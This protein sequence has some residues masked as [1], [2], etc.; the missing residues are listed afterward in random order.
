LLIK[1][2]KDHLTMK[3]KKNIKIIIVAL[4]IVSFLVTITSCVVANSKVGETDND[5]TEAVVNNDTESLTDEI[6]ESDTEDYSLYWPDGGKLNRKLY[7]ALSEMSDDE[8]IRVQITF[9]YDEPDKEYFIELAAKKLGLKYDKEE[10]DIVYGSNPK[11]ELIQEYREVKR[12]IQEEYEFERQ[13]EFAEKYLKSWEIGQD[14]ALR[15]PKKVIFAELSKK[16]IND[17]AMIE[18]VGCIRT[19]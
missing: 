1:I 10:G 5:E 18:D 8:T 19:D 2:R 17:L 6:T 7:L 16:E 13:V 12:Q 3:S 11:L 9:L 4:L 15:T 14:I